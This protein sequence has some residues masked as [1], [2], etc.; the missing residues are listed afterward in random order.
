MLLKD[1]FLN[2][3]AGT[4]YTKAGCLRGRNQL[5]IFYVWTGTLGATATI[6]ASDLD[7]PTE[8]DDTDWVQVTD[9]TLTNPTSGGGKFAQVVGNANHKWYRLKF[10]SPSG[11]GNLTVHIEHVAASTRS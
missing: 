11:S 8:A 3:S 10:A 9:V 5:A 2:Y 7:K 4:K 1:E 6:W